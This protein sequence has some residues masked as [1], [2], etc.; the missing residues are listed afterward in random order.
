M[1]IV[2]SGYHSGSYCLWGIGVWMSAVESVF[3]GGYGVIDQSMLLLRSTWPKVLPVLRMFKEHELVD[4]AAAC[5]M[6]D[7]VVVKAY[8]ALSLPFYAVVR[9]FVGHADGPVPVPRR[10][11]LIFG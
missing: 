8:H 9:G 11:L 3:N 2:N 6:E 10:G 4:R 5:L 1:A 7:R